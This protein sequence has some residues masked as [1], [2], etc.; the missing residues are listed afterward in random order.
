[1][2]YLP[3]FLLR[4]DFNGETS[5][6]GSRGRHGLGRG[7]GCLNSMSKS[8]RWRMSNSMGMYEGSRGTK[9]MFRSKSRS[10]TGPSK[11][12]SLSWRRL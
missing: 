3:L 4:G 11:S 9:Q 10:A 12:R 6:S 8:G 7:G 1:M 2:M 5:V